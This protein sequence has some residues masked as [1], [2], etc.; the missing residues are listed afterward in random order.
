MDKLL[1]CE[2]EYFPNPHLM[3]IYAGF[4]ELQ[5]LGIIDLSIK[6]IK[7]TATS[8]PL[9]NALI[10]KKHRV[11]YDTIDGLSW[12]PGDSVTNLQ[13]FQRTFTADFYFK[14]S[15]DPRMQDYRPGN[16]AVFPLG[17]N[18]NVQ[19]K[20][21]MLGYVDG[22]NEKFKYISKTNAFLKSISKKRFFYADDFEYYP[23]KPAKHKVLFL[24]RLWSPE[25]AKSE[26]SRDFRTQINATRI[27]C[28]E[29][30]KKAFGDRFTGGLQLE[31]YSK[32]HYPTLAMPTSLTGKAGYLQAVKSHSICIATTGLHKSIGW[33][34]AEYVAASRAIVTEPLHF[35]LP[36][37]FHRDANFLEF[38]T[39]EQLLTAVEKLLLNEELTLSLMKNNFHYYN[40][41]VKPQ[42]L[43]LNTLI[44]ILNE[45]EDLKIHHR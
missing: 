38:E 5:K 12:I 10:N 37:N 39:P 44:T 27:A 42:N 25:E 7:S 20:R 4:F 36:G 16:C 45:S 30:C 14:R 21:N 29:A 34:L 3:Q 35:S 18:Y 13:H 33:K 19:P 26:R 2:L 9:I 15:Y 11:V 24:T 23:V 41:Y 1:A 22:W 43:V 6:K 17:L 32:K 8:I 28:I 31:S 40:N